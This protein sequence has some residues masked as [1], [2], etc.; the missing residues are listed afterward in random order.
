[1][2][3]E[4]A[5]IILL[6]GVVLL[7]MWYVAYQSG[8]GHEHVKLNQKVSNISATGAFINMPSEVKPNTAGIV[9]WIA[10][11]GL[12]GILMS[13]MKVIERIQTSTGSI[14]S[15]GRVG[16]PVPSFFNTEHR[17]LVDYRPAIDNNRG[18]ILMTLFTI[19]TIIFA[20]LIVQEG[21]GLART[22]FIG[23][24]AMM[25]F[26]SLAEVVMVYYAYF[27]PHTQVAEEREH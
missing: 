12:V 23:I 15:G 10:V 6:I 11:F 17:W 18:L 24:Y 25:L 20:A 5:I 2:K 9:S 1:M 21:L 26:L 16:V 13:Y 3:R 4:T 19:T 8:N 27:I 14:V 22:Q 7:P